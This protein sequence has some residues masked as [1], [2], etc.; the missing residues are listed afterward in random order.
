MELFKIFGTIGLKDEGFTKG[1]GEATKTGESFGSKF[2]SVMAGIG[3][4]TVVGLTAA[5]TAFGA[6]AVSALKA[7]GDLE[8]SLGGVETLFKSSADTVIANAEKAYLTAGVSANAYMQQVTSFSA[9]LLQSLGGDTKKAAA[10]ADMAVIDMA[11]NA[12]KMGSS[13]ESIQYAYQGFAKQNYTMLDNLKLGFGGTKEEMQRLLVEAGKISGMK[14][15]ITNLNDVYSAVHVIQTELGITGTTALEGMTTLNGAFATAKASLQ[16]FLS[17]AGNTDD[18]VSSI[19]NVF[20]IVA[21]RMGELLPRLT[22]GLTSIISQLIPKIP[23]LLQRMLPSMVE[24]ASTLIN[25][26]ITALPGL[27]TELTAAMPMVVNAILTMLPLLA[28]AAVNI[29]TTLSSGLS[30][31]LPTLIPVAVDAILTL[32]D[33]LLNNIDTI[34]DAGIEVVL[35]LVDGLTNALPILLDKAPEIIMKLIQAIIENTPKMYA[36]GGKVIQAFLSA[37]WDIGKKAW[38]IT[39]TLVNDYV[40]KPIG[41]FFSDMAEAGTNLIQGLWNGIKDAGRWLRDK[42]SGFFSGVV[43]DIKG[44][45]GIKSPSKL[46]AEIGKMNMQG[47]AKGFTDN[48]SFV[49]KRVN[50]AMDSVLGG[51]NNHMDMGLNFSSTGGISGTNQSTQ[52]AAPIAINQYIQAVPQTPSEQATATLA[53]FQNV[54]WVI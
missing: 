45:F 12:N 32:V 10:A 34:V 11:D 28:D 46:F 38:E 2:G 53:A 43:D 39:T 35:A 37:I 20:N 3:K 47:F 42:I 21:D 18:L 7:G 1:I 14:Y 52:S 48:V 23:P 8:Q 54:R 9:S 51:I 16:N 4:A 6:L 27:L 13:M 5:T 26:V 24:G 36:A 31:Q 33:S 40:I 17:G 49:K 22:E 19:S 44:F 29:V 30:E 50:N 25:G 15:D 41:N